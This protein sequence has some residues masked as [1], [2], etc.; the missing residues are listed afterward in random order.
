MVL[1]VIR[2]ESQW[3]TNF[4]TSKLTSSESSSVPTHRRCDADN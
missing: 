4:V 1:R 3:P 2:A